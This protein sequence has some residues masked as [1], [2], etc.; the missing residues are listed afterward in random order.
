MTP[1]RMSKCLIKPGTI[2]TM[3]SLRRILRGGGVVINGD[4]I[5]N[6]FSSDD[7][8]SQHGFSG[9]VINV[10]DLTLIPGF[11]Q[12]HIHLCQTVF[13]GLAENLSLLDWLRM[14]IFPLEAAHS[15]SSLRASALL[16]LSELIGSGTTTIMDMGT[17]LHEE[18]I[19]NAVDESGARAFV[20]KAMMDIN[21]LY[22]RFREGTD[23]ALRSVTNEVRL[24]HGAANGRIQYA[25]APRFVLSCTD[26]LL[27]R[28]FELS[29]EYPGMRF[30]THAAESKSELAAVRNR[31]GVDNIEHFDRLGILGENTCL[32]HCIWLQE[33][34]V[35]L[36]ADRRANV[37]H[38]PSSNL[39]L[40]SGVARIPEMLKRGVSVSLGADGAACNNTLDMFEEMRL[41]ALIQKPMHGA[42]VMSAEEVFAIATIGGARALGLQETI[43]SVE[44]GKKAD[45]VLLDLRQSF[46]RIWHDHGRDLYSAIVYS[47]SP[48]NVRSTMIDGHWVYRDGEHL[49]IDVEHTMR[50]AQE[51]LAKLLG[52]VEWT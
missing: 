22:P 43:G 16:G 48:A 35:G 19:I 6:I 47:G 30:H 38:C 39:K 34:E 10:P 45:L 42:E 23:D 18:E 8:T 40:G 5:E 3:D 17:I 37:L 11:V 36:L 26:A 13:R 46:G 9:E 20:G 27:R 51:E 25:V 12:T 24:W 33:K 44:E 21:E 50:M 49:R 4:T 29:A 1:L 14:K 2:I 15:A 28:A 52:R 32:A 41:A 7:L 31:C